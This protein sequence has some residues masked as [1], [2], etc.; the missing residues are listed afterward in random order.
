MHLD[1]E[2]LVPC[3]SFRCNVLDYVTTIR[4]LNSSYYTPQQQAIVLS[5]DILSVL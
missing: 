1:R 4:I 3:E 2:C 5:E